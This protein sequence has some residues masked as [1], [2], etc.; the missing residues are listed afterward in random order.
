MEGR[1]CGLSKKSAKSKN[2]VYSVGGGGEEHNTVYLD[3][4]L[5]ILQNNWIKNAPKD[6]E[7]T[8]STWQI[9]IFFNRYE[10]YSGMPWIKSSKKC[11]F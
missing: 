3:D 1:G 9:N 5:K 8:Q 6:K 4:G 11:K 2:R 10:A 7:C